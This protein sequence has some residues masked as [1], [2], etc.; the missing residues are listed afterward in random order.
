MMTVSLW[1]E[2]GVIDDSCICVVK[3]HRSAKAWSVR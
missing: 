2:G 3:M 1:Q